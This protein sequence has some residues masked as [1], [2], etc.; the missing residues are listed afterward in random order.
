MS[1]LSIIKKVVSASAVAL[2]T[3]CGPSEAPES[4]TS[5]RSV[6]PPAGATQLYLNGIILTM[7]EAQPRAEAI[8][9]RNGKILAVGSEDAVRSA[10]GQ[11]AAIVDLQG[12]TLMP[13]FIDAHGH[14]TMTLEFLAYDNVASPP[15]GPVKTVD[16]IVQILS[17]NKA[18][19]PAGQWIMGAGYDESLLKEQRHP[20]R[21]DLDKVST[22]HPIFIRHVSGHL[23]VCNSKCL[24]L[25]GITAE[26]EDP[27]GGVFRRVS[28]SREPNGVL[29]EVAL[30][31][32]SKVLPTLNN[33]ARMALL[34]KAQTYYARYGITS[35]QDG[36]TSPD[37]LAFLREA[38]RGDRLKLD[39]IA[40]PTWQYTDLLESEF[41]PRPGYDNHFRIGGVKLVLDGSPQGKTAWLTHPYHR[42][43]DG[44]SA[45]YRGYPI[46]QD[47]QLEGY[48]REFFAK[49]WQILA[50]ANGDAA[51]DQLIRTITK[52]NGEQGEADRRTVMIHAQTVR[53]DQLDVMNELSIIPSFFVAHTFYWGDWH[54]DS[55]LGEVRAHRISPL[56]SAT[57]RGIPYTIHNDTPIVPPDMALLLWSGVNRETR[58]GQILG[59]DQRATVAQ[60]LRAVTI[61]AAR[62]H[63]EEDIKGSLEPGKLADLVI[64]DRNPLSENPAKLAEILVLKTI[65]EGET[66]FSRDN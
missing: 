22:E 3:A 47:E 33:L 36:A 5:T 27:A 64:L 23:G 63:F 56:Q 11:E 19:I 32:I 38:A 37:G 18:D 26:T 48:I 51:A 59:A 12:N 40:Y 24:E 4:V 21:F 44:Q 29:E 42:P 34:D 49:G 54:R 2:I 31:E 55:V 30:F 13:G 14:F 28:G 61:D 20:T 58:S 43:P 50:H 62:Q 10:A 7:V 65:K 53:D 25:G 45:S 57:Q 6:A 15:V 1:L 39:V 41:P 8:A 66:I 35:V 46:L 52:V 9:V 17:A 16:D 60:A